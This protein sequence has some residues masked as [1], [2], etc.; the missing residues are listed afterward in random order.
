MIVYLFN[1]EN[2]LK[3]KEEIKLVKSQFAE[4]SD[5]IAEHENMLQVLYK[6]NKISKVIIVHK[7]SPFTSLRI[8][9]IL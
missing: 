3:Y 1:T 6:A 9:Y 7:R 4:P 2:I 8:N 5:V